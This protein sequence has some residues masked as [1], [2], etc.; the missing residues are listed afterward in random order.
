MLKQIKKGFRE[1]KYLYIKKIGLPR[2]IKKMEK[3]G[4]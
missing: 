4:L 1:L 3:Q 2:T